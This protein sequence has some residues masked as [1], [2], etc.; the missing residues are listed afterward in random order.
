MLSCRSLGSAPSS[1][2][3]SV[4]CLP[5]FSFVQACKWIF[6]HFHYS[7][8]PCDLSLWVSWKSKGD[9]K[10]HCEYMTCENIALLPA[11]ENMMMIRFVRRLISN[12]ID[13][14]LQ[15]FDHQTSLFWSTWLIGASK[16][17]IWFQVRSTFWHW[18]PPSR[19]PLAIHIRFQSI[20]IGTTN[21]MSVL[22]QASPKCKELFAT[23]FTIETCR[24]A[25][26]EWFSLSD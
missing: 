1:G 8:S 17:L 20:P 9:G 13:P 6:S 15:F 25:F 24:Q 12:T 21:A 7:E 14:F 18:P 16:W 5:G 2:H 10:R 22:C 4:T 3:F 26:L 11:S 19:F 23:S